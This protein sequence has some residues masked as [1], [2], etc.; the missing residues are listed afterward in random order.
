[1]V[2]TLRDVLKPQSFS[3]EARGACYFVFLGGLDHFLA[4]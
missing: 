3:A 4:E 1:M 2:A